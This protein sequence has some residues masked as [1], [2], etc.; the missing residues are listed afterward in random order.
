MLLLLFCGLRARSPGTG[1]DALLWPWLKERVNGWTCAHD[2]KTS[3]KAEVAGDA[4][5][6]VKTSQQHAC[7]SVTLVAAVVAAAA[8]HP[9]P[10]SC[11][12]TTTASTVTHLAVDLLAHV[13][14]GARACQHAPHNVSGAD[15]L[16]AFDL[17]HTAQHSVTQHV[18]ICNVPLLETRKKRIQKQ[19]QL[20]DRHQ[21]DTR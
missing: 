18:R 21:V 13:W 5:E 2:T 15:T 9:T 4:R 16:C 20:T 14:V 6:G 7:Q 11:Q 10:P 1:A 3:N 17:Q 19:L 8:Y 12:H